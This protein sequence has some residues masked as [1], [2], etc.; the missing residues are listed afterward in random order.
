MVAIWQ[1]RRRQHISVWLSGR[2][3][4]SLRQA[5]FTEAYLPVPSEVASGRRRQLVKILVQQDRSW[6]N[7]EGKQTPLRLYNSLS[8]RKELFKVSPGG[9]VK[10]FVCGPT[11]YD[12]VHL[13]H[14]RTYLAFDI[15]ARYLKASGYKVRY[16]MN[17]TDVAE[18]LIERAE[19]L[20]RDPLELAHEYQA[21]FVEDMQSLAINSVDEYERASDYIPQMIAQIKGL[22]DR[23]VAYETETGV[24]FQVSK[25]PKFGE[26]SAQSPEELGLRRLELCSSK[27]SPEDFS[28]WRKY[29]KGLRWDSPWGY[30][31]PGWH[32]EDT[33]ISMTHFGETYD[34]HGGA[35]E[36]IFPHHEAEIAQAEALTG[37]APFVKYWLHTGLLNVR[38]RKM[39]KS[40]G[41]VVRIRDAIREYG[42]A[43]LRLYF[44]SFHYRQP[45]VLSATG[46]R[47]ATRE[48]DAL[49]RG[50]QTFAK[51][52]PTI[53]L[54]QQRRLN[55]LLE[56]SESAFKSNMDNDFDTPKAI[57]VLRILSKNLPR[58]RV[59]EEVKVTAEARFRRMADVFGMLS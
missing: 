20:K 9:E 38:G 35:S 30:G 49:N 27:R 15:I 44:A 46:L 4:T 56:R 12:Y 41:N 51:S 33:A 43:V 25:F 32:I 10:F 54:K 24:Y 55:L 45:M 59:N 18:R 37:K 21:T 52:E 14:A 16:L 17:V 11:V 3:M 57:N 36:L 47:R 8:R 28:L 31:R 53:N 6:N 48:L 22:V 2:Q 23:G 26:L 13:G 1:P 34:M 39:S 7:G 40:L 42:A 58:F 50:L 19:E 29:D 5:G